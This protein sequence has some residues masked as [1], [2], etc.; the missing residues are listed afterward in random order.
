MPKI[1]YVE[2]NGT[3]HCLD[4]PVGVTV[5]EGAVQAGLPWID[6]DCGG[7]CSC[8]TCHIIVDAAWFEKAGPP[9]EMER[10]MLELAVEPR[11]HSRLS[12]QIRVDSKLDGLVVHLPERQR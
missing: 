3:E 8:A 5:M 12:C 2:P 10:D 9:D 6:A 1:I 4:V 11:E 7:G